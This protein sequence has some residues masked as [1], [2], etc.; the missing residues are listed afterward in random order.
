MCNNLKLRTVKVLWCA[1]LYTLAT[2]PLVRAETT[3]KATTS[4]SIFSN[5]HEIEYRSGGSVY[6]EGLING[7]FVG[8]SWA[9]ADSGKKTASGAEPAFEIR[10]QNDALAEDNGRMLSNGWHWSSAQELPKTPR[11]SRH[12]VVELSNS[13][14]PVT[15]RVHTLLDGTPILTRWLEITNRSDQPLGLTELSPWAGRLWREA[16]SIYLGH[17]LRW[18]VPWEGWFGWTRLQPGPTLIRNARDLLWDDPY[19]V[20]RNASR[21]EYFFGELA[22]AADYSMEFTN[23]HGLSFKVGP[24]ASHVLRVIMAG[25]A[26][27]TPAVHLGY[28]QGDFDAAVQAMHDHIRSSV[29]PICAPG[30]CYK[31]QYLIPEDWPMTVYRGK[32]FNETNMK[33][34]IDVAAAVGAEAFILDGPNWGSVYGNWLVPNKERFPNGLKP[35]VDYAHKKGLLFGLY[36]ESEG[37]RDGKTAH[38]KGGAII[39]PWKESAIYQEHPEWFAPGLN[40]NL[41][42]PDAAAYFE[43]EVGKIIDFYHLDIYRHDQNG[44]VF[45]PPG[46]GAGETLRQGRFIENDYWRHYQ[47]LDN[48]MER[49]QATHPEVILQQAAAGNFRLD[50]STVAAFREQFTS[51]RATMPYVYRMLSGMSVYLP[52][53]ILVNAN[54]MAWPKDRPD[55]DTTLRGA[56]ALGNTPMLFNAILPKSVDELTPE[57]RDRFLHYATIYKNFMRPLLPTCR[58]FHH[59][60]VNGTGGVESGDWFA[61]EFASPDHQKDWAVIIRLAKAAP[62]PYVLKFKGLDKNKKYKAT[63]DNSGRTVVLDGAVLMKTGIPIKLLSNRD[64]E[65][66]L[67]Q[68]Q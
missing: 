18:Q 21:H 42:I 54:G 56:F 58:V 10:L 62:N 23:D 19:F 22:W 61:M 39:A 41:S 38:W 37:G 44:I 47:A 8:E 26:V 45:F 50:L 59:A 33:K 3:P 36:V 27:V 24:V 67:L 57:I 46:P 40:L 25:E 51:D 2:M 6:R 28:I 15:V 48:A 17:S 20:L 35:L 7:Q 12:V 31:V 1:M 60:P 32:D 11:G 30:R 14:L 13:I 63:F 29:S 65:L 43:T 53:E 55:L 68:A 64:S 66:L 4:L 5:R 16:G 9:F 49:I 52:P 34:C